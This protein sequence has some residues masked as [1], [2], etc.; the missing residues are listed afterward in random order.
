MKTKPETKVGGVRLQL[1]SWTKM[2]ALMQLLGRGWLE[3]AIDR[4][5][6]KHV[7]KQK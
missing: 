1:E 6:R 2:R 3:K 5:Y 7:E 4:E